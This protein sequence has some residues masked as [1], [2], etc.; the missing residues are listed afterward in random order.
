MLSICKKI[1]KKCPTELLPLAYMKDAT[2]SVKRLCKEIFLETSD[3]IFTELLGI[4]NLPLR[5][6]DDYFLQ[7]PLNMYDLCSEKKE[8]LIYTALI[9]KILQPIRIAAYY[10]DEQ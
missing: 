3:S 7:T 2:R 4:S 9:A 8:V 6:M 10:D 1:Q 5:E